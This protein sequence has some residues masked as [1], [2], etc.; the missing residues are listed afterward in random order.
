MTN[1]E[2]L[3]AHLMTCSPEDAYETLGLVMWSY[4]KMFTDSRLA[5]IEW[6]KK[7]SDEK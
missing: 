3:A 7:E 2:K 4:A 6:L 5:I 1:Q